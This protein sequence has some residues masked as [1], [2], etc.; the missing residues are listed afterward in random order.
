MKTSSCDKDFPRASSPASPGVG[1]TSHP[2]IE[3]ER[4]LLGHPGMGFQPARSPPPSRTVV[5]ANVCLASTCGGSRSL[6]DYGWSSGAHR[7]R[8]APDRGT[9]GDATRNPRSMFPS[10]G[11]QQGFPVLFW[12]RRL[13][14]SSVPADYR[15]Y[16]SL[17]RTGV[18]DLP[19]LKR[20]IFPNSSRVVG[21]KS[22]S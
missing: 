16:W 8:W 13:A 1:K 11:A 4:S 18:Q 15:S 21:P 20:S 2:G 19:G 17:S 3:P 5:R 7:G 6:K 22:F 12:M 10:C 14:R 9:R